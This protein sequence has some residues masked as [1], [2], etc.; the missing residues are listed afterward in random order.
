MQANT[1]LR[2]GALESPWQKPEGPATTPQVLSGQ[3]YD[4]LIV[5]AGITGLTAGLLLQQAGKQVIIAEAQTAG[6]GTTGGTSAHI[7]NFADTTYAEARSAFGTDGAQLFADAISEGAGLIRNNIENLRIECDYAEKKGYIYAENEDEV[8]QLADIFEGM[9]QVGVEAD[10]TDKA[11]TPVPFLK[12]LEIPGQAQFHPLK[13]LQAIRSAFLEA[14]GILLPHTFIEKL[15]QE[16]GVHVANAGTQQIRAYKVIYATHIPPGITVFSFRCAP[17]RSYMLALKLKAGKYP[18]ALIYD[19]QEPYHYVRT[20]EIDG[21]PL[22]LIGGNDHKTGHDD[23][24]KAF[25]DLEKYARNYYSVSS[26][27]YRWSS[28]YYI[29]ADGFPYIGQIPFV[30]DG[31]LTATGFN[32]NGMMLGSISAK[33][34]ADQVLGVENRY[35]QLFSPYRIKPIDGF[36][37]LVKENADV[38]YH[39]VA[40]RFGIPETDSLN[41]IRP[42][43]GKIVE[44][45]G[46]KLAVYRDEN[47]TVNALSPTCTHAGCL[48]NFNA[49]ECTWDCP[50]HGGRYAIDGSV[51]T[52]PPTQ[53]L[54]Q[55]SINL[56]NNYTMPTKNKGAASAA[57]GRSPEA[58]SALKELFV[59]ELKDIYWAEQHLVKALPK[60]IKGAT[61]EEL[62]NT[63]Q[64]HLAETEGHVSRLEK[65]FE[66]I[67]EKAKAVKCE[68][69]AGLLKEAEE[70]MTETDKGTEVRD[71]AIIS[72]AQKVE[73]YEIASYG[74]MRTLAGTLG[75]SEAQELLQ[76]TLDEEKNA[77]QLLTGVAENYVNEAAAAE[78]E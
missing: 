44:L 15:D 34:L 50:C 46:T 21:E 20:H 38:A 18:D 48:V 75:F 29:P 55:I 71:A 30:A 3:V 41:S 74:T 24:E 40:D 59:D 8:K 12:A 52:G 31:I 76:Q 54:K 62:K 4:C 23:P 56:Q 65:V 14:G 1:S 2:D 72:A 6:F 70:L 39:F 17:Y 57:T 73:H 51:I 27:K 28:Q 25:D 53:A 47:G 32:G 7:N 37:E 77:D 68:A 66:S 33:I 19:C 11:P 36:M 63:I 58:E 67:G 61:S 78:T 16:D 69:M 13:Y 49:A 45:G 43:T 9:Q 60:M 42:G 10:Y 22:L 64:T 5:G 35:S 26:V